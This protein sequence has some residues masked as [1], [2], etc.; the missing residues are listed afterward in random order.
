MTRSERKESMSHIYST[1]S[2]PHV[3]VSVCYIH[4]NEQ[5]VIDKNASTTNVIA[6]KGT[7]NNLKPGIYLNNSSY[8]Y[9]LRALVVRIPGYRCRDPG[10]DSRRY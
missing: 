1:L 3:D 6:K 9:R 10:L 8:I 2:N 7:L 4:L 5:Q